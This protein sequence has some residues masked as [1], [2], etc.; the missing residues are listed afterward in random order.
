MK[1]LEHRTT[2]DIELRADK[3]DGA[4]G[5]FA[6]YAAT[7]N[8][9]DSYGTAFA[10]GAFEKT[11]KERGDKVPVLYNH[12]KNANVGVP[13]LLEVDKTGLRVEARLFDDGAEGTVL[14]KR[15][16][17]GARFGMSHY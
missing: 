14:L 6:G 9:V 5:G 12:D 10:P 3:D 4:S 2:F 8:R 16:R 15:L 1:Q 13:E 11:L 7:F 17:Q